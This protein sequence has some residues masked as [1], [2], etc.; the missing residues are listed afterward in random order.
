MYQPT[1]GRFLSQD[2]LGPDGVDVLFDN[3]AYGAALDRMRNLYGYCGNNPV[4][5]VDPSGLVPIAVTMCANALLPSTCVTV[6][7]NPPT[8]ARRARVAFHAIPRAATVQ[9]RLPM[10]MPVSIPPSPSMAHMPSPMPTP[11]PPSPMMMPIPPSP[12]TMPMPGF[13]PMVMPIP[14]VAPPVQPPQPIAF[15]IPQPPPLPDCWLLEAKETRRG[16]IC[17]GIALPITCQ[18][19]GPPPRTYCYKCASAVNCP[20]KDDDCR[21]VCNMDNTVTK[22]DCH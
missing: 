15:N 20:N 13:A 19:K 3:N 14:T 5:C 21:P 22:C 6:W 1:L 4:N 12:A 7:I 9:T 10:P 16:Q 18:R 17:Q 11:V 2:P 8:T